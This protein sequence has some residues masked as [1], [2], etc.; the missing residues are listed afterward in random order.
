MLA[1]NSIK[2]LRD[3]VKDEI[4]LKSF[5][6]AVG[7]QWSST[8]TFH[9]ERLR[10]ELFDRYEAASMLLD[11]SGIPQLQDR[12]VSI[13]H[14]KSTGGYCVTERD[15]ALSV[16]F[17]VELNERV[18]PRHL[19]QVADASETIDAPSHPA[20]WTAKEAAF[21]CFH[22]FQ[23]PRGLKDIRIASWRRL[24]LEGAF[25]FTLEAPVPARGVIVDN[26]TLT[27]A[28]CVILNDSSK[29]GGF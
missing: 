21:K 26:G 11:L 1:E 4:G 20:L 24:A 3:V 17:D 7:S 12:S 22:G 6:L 5:E 25:A 19:R 15:S 18:K 13:S 16:G 29:A 14:C 8:S 2:T 28:I 9:R 27:Y 10:Q 23:Q